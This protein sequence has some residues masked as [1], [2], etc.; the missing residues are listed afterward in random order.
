MKMMS[1]MVFL[2]IFSS[3]AFGGNGTLP[4]N[5]KIFIIAAHSRRCI[6]LSG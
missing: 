6:D 3:I 2:G 4:L 5:K 1:L